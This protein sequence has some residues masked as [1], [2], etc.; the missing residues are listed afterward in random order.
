MKSPNYRIVCETPSYVLIE[1]VGPWD[2][3][4]TVTN[5]PEEV[6]RQ[7]A[8]GLGDRRLYYIDSQ[9]DTDQLLVEDGRF[10]GFHCGGPEE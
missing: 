10:A 8:P 7:L 3:V 6:V 5:N 2:K 4:P 9:G 1:D